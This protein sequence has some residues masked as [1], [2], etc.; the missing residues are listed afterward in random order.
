MG[1][2]GSP[3]VDVCSNGYSNFSTN[4]KGTN[5]SVVIKCRVNP[6]AIRVVKK[7]S[8]LGRKEE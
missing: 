2:Y 6:S 4:V 1:I 7:Q 5:Y 3:H 8:D